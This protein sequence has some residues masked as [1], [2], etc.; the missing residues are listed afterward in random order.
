MKRLV[1]VI[2]F[3]IIA[4]GFCRTF[5]QEWKKY[6][7]SAKALAG[8]KKFDE[9]VATYTKAKELLEKDSVYSFAYSQVCTAMADLLNISGQQKKVVPFYIEARNTIYKISGKENIAYA[10][11]TD[12]LAQSYMTVDP[13]GAEAYFLEA[14]DLRE[15]LFNN[16]SLQYAISCNSLGVYYSRTGQYKKS[17][18]FHLQAKQIREEKLSADDPEL[19]RTYNNLA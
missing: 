19:G 5:S 8:S 17:V 10:N 6:S 13:A 9:A 4:S 12:R 18:L 15:K 2:L 11:L 16:K 1:S 7:D 3:M 14:R